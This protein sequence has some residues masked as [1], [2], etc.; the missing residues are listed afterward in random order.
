MRLPRVIV[1]V[2]LLAVLL[3]G[4]A[5]APAPAPTAAATPTSAPAAEQPTVTPAAPAGEIVLEVAG[6]DG[7]S[8]SFTMDELKALPAVEGWGGIKSSTG[9]IFPPTMLKGVALTEVVKS[10]GGATAENGINIQAK[11]G[12]A[13]TLSY[14]QMTKGDFITYDPGTGDE[15]TVDEPLTVILAY[16]QDG[17]PLPVESDGNLRLAVVSEKN[18]QVVDGHWAV[19]WVTKVEVK[20]LS[21]EWTIDLEGAITEVMDRGT[22]ESC[23]SSNCHQATWTDDEGTEW[24]GVPL[25]MMAGRVDD[26]NKHK[27]VAFNRAVAEKG[28]QIEVTAAD[29]YSVTLD[30]ELVTFED[31]IILAYLANEEPLEEKYFPVR[32]VGKGLKKGEMVGQVSKIRLIG[33]E[34]E[35]ASAPAEPTAAHTKPHAEGTPAAE[36]GKGETVLTVK[37][38]VSTELA[39]CMNS[40]KDLGVVEVQAEHPKQGLQTYSGVP[41]A[42]ILEKAGVDA[43]ASK[44]AIV[45]ADGYAA[46]A[47]LAEVEASTDALVAIDD[48]GTLMM[49]LPGMQ[50]SFWV[51]NLATLELK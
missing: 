32:L 12:Y 11:D 47:S 18:N 5:Q 19:K 6:V 38:A 23:T 49:V 14:D 42:K 21:A 40:L 34:G 26:D 39:L 27:G 41:L 29:G 20:P 16:E 2:A 35:G 37:G 48:S 51:K 50:S 15:T 1:A 9:R 45:A 31:E 22:F 13:M 36:A 44:I 10:V 4:C 30:S 28:Y 43:G 8:K 25:W 17:K 33:I 3:A 24:I 7:K 46:E